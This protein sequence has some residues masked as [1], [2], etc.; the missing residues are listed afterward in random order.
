MQTWQ[1]NQQISGLGSLLAFEVE[2][3]EAAAFNVLNKPQL[4]DVSYNLGE[5]KSLACD[6]STTTHSNMSPE[7]RSSSLGISGYHICWSV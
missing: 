1:H 5:S 3:G 7:D 4:I 2:G 6:P